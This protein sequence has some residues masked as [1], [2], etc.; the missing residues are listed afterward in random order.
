M[1]WPVSSL[2]LTSLQ[3]RSKSSWRTREQRYCSTS[4][5]DGLESVL[6]MDSTRFDRQFFKSW[7]RVSHVELSFAHRQARGRSYTLAHPELNVPTDELLSSGTAVAG[8][9]GRSAF[10]SAS[11]PAVARATSASN[12]HHRDPSSL[13]IRATPRVQP[14]AT[15]SRPLTTLQR[16]RDS[17][18]P[19]TTSTSRSRAVTST[20]ATERQ[21]DITRSRAQAPIRAS[22]E[23]SQ[24][25]GRRRVLSDA[26]PARTSAAPGGPGPSS[27][28]SPFSTRRSNPPGRGGNTASVTT[29]PSN[30]QAESRRARAT[31]ATSVR[32][33]R[34]L[35]TVTP[36]GAPHADREA[37]KFVARSTSTA[38]LNIAR[39][40][41]S[42][43]PLV[44]RGTT[45][46]DSSV[47][48]SASPRVRAKSTT[49]VAARPLR[50]PS[51][52]P[53]NRMKGTKPLPSHLGTSTTMASTAAVVGARPTT[54]AFDWSK[55]GTHLLFGIPCIV[56]L[57]TERSLRFR[58][59]VRYIGCIAGGTAEWVGVEVSEALIPR[60]AVNL[61]WFDKGTMGGGEHCA[62]TDPHS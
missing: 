22:A 34:S 29:P 16:P 4:N 44:K 38:S 13:S 37:K 57:L 7:Q 3:I 41:S 35:A 20:R 8:P 1:R 62:T 40:P 28:T 27:T 32:S 60:E 52:P 33:Q 55:A 36:S 9:V 50:A 25:A 54:T 31:S 47:S 17:S 21:T 26:G 39:T 61:D 56:T 46:L 23:A 14:P 58:A 5:A 51:S 15:L 42:R 59:T 43:A 19:S 12:R 49:I 18:S 30:Q 48:A 11:R 53:P 2:R 6:C 45:A 24:Q 10:P